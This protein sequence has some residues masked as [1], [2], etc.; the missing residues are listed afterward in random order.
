MLK[1]TH[2]S[3]GLLGLA[4][5]LVFFFSS[6]TAELMGGGA[7]I[8]L[9]KR[10]IVYGL[11]VLIPVMAAAGLTG[12][13]AAGE[14]QE[15]LIKT[16]MKRMGIVATNGIFVLVPCAIILDRLAAAGDFGSWFYTLQTLEFL[17]G[18]LNIVLMAM[19]CYSGL[20][21]AG[22]LGR[23]HHAARIN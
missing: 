11:F 7:M 6:L 19:N 15:K 23:R 22:R 20:L 4:I 16:K 17:G 8:A 9:V 18:G 14:R 12:R 2:R 5:L 3:A 13:M 10:S 21:L 1:F